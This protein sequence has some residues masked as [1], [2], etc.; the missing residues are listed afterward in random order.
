LKFPDVSCSTIHRHILAVSA[1]YLIALLAVLFLMYF[2]TDGRVAYTMDSLTYRDAALNFMSGNPMQ[3]TNVVTLFPE[4]QPLI[5]WP[6]AYPAIWAS[7]AYLG[8]ADIDA[9][10]SILNPILLGMTLLIVFWICLMIT[11]KPFIACVVAIM[12][13]FVPSTMT[14]YGHAWSETLFIPLIL[15]SYA[16]LLRY[17]ISREKFI[18]IAVAAIF[19]GLANWVRYAGVAFLPILV[20]SI[21]VLSGAAFGKRIMHATGAVLLSTALVFPLWFRNWQLSGNISGSNR[22]GSGNPDQWV[23]DVVTIADLFEH[24]LF[25]FDYAIRSNLEIPILLTI[26]FATIGAFRRHGT[27]W[28]RPV[29]I[30]LPIVWLTGYLLFLLYARVAQK[31][32]PMDLRMLAVAFPFALFA[33]TPAVDA[34]FANRSLNIRKI[35]IILMLGLLINSGRSEADRVRENYASAGVPGWRSDYALLFR[36]MRNTS[37]IGRAIQEAIGPISPSELI[38]T[39]DRALYIRYLTGAKAYSPHYGSDCSGW[40]DNFGKGLLLIRSRMLPPWA[41][42]CLK[43]PTQWRLLQAN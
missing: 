29:E 42:D 5:V 34:A 21:F 25:A 11:R 36:D 19:I 28:L 40:E 4:R 43:N 24:S 1:Y 31:G 3:S 20:F 33:L 30:W 41:I 32:V 18:W 16:A 13:G 37:P 6:P 9:V 39:N 8:N 26:V 27:Q 35:L 22:G 7:A 23:N 2:A 12:S 38:L 17:R 10:P 15:L 14:V